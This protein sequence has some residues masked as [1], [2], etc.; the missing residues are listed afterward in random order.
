MGILRSYY[1]RLTFTEQ[2]KTFA[3]PKIAGYI[4]GN[5]LRASAHAVHGGS[6]EDIDVDVVRTE[7][8]ISIEHE[9]ASVNSISTTDMT[10][11]KASARHFVADSMKATITSTNIANNVDLIVRVIIEHI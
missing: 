7:F 5:M 4:R 1:V 9:Y 2:S 10:S 3:I 6:G 8:G 11:S